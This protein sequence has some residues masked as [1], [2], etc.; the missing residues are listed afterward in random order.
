MVGRRLIKLLI[1]PA[2]P[3]IEAKIGPLR[4]WMR[5]REDR[6]SLRTIEDAIGVIERRWGVTSISNSGPS[7]SSPIFV[8]AA[9]WR[10]GST[11]VQRL[12]SSAGTILVWGE[13]YEHCDLIRLLAASLTGIRE[14]YPPDGF[15]A[16]SKLSETDTEDKQLWNRWIA[17]LYPD[18]VHLLQ[19]HR[20]FMIALFQTPAEKLGYP[21]WGLKEV[22]LTIEHAVYLKWLFPNAR[23]LLLHRNPYDAYRSFRPCRG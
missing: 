5:V 4:Q 11:L 19:A 16:K 23:F 10:S 2:R 13:P 6:R 15:L 22:R 18:P 7:A 9:G 17:N 14:Q 20:A 12:I 21:R 3:Y 8:L 1:S